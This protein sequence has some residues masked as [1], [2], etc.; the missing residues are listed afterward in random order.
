[1]SPVAVILVHDNRCALGSEAILVGV[2]AYR[3]DAW[4]AEIEHTRQFVTDTFHE[5]D[6]IATQTGVH[7]QW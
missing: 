6:E 1:M 3:G 2:A 5:W 7:M 4:Q